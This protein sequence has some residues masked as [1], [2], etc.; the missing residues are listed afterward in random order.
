MP[1]QLRRLPLLTTSGT[2]VC[3]NLRQT[4]ASAIR[5]DPDAY[6]D[7]VLGQPRDS[8]ISKILSPTAWGGA[9]E[10]SILSA[11]FGV[12]IDSIDVATGTVHRFGEDMAYENRGIVVYSGI[13]YDALTLVE[14]LSET[15]VFPNLTAIGVRERARM[16]C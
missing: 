11:H 16:K 1:L 14:G 2:D 12:E 10:L 6:P 7:I 3:Q 5:A 9:I 8:Y 13:H 4:V 15:T